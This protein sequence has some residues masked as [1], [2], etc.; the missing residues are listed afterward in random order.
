M[1]NVELKPYPI[2]IIYIIEKV[3]IFYDVQAQFIAASCLWIQT[4]LRH[5]FFPIICNG[6]KEFGWLGCRSFHNLTNN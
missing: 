5:F 1:Q 6:K 2:V 3:A 4:H